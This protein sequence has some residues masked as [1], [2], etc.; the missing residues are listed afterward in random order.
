MTSG[1]FCFLKRKRIY[2]AW[3]MWGHVITTESLVSLS[4]KAWSNARTIST[5]NI[6]QHFWIVLW[7]AVKEMAKRAQ[8]L[9]TS[10]N[11]ATQIWPF[12]TWSNPIQHL[13]TCSNM[14]PQGVQTCLTRCFLQCCVEMLRSLGRAFTQ[15]IYLFRCVTLQFFSLRYITT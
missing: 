12:S 2:N 3:S 13:S 7:D 9:T 11:V 8:Q 4:L 14:L 5:E 1:H 6:L 15:R 10:K